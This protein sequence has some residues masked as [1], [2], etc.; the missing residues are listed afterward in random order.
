MSGVARACAP[1]GGRGEVSQGQ[2]AEGPRGLS[3]LRGTTVCR[4]FSVSWSFTGCLP[5]V[6]TY[7][8]R[9]ERWCCCKN[10]RRLSA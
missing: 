8:G 6:M 9:I 7:H 3:D 1:K 2:L 5:A 10:D 4:L